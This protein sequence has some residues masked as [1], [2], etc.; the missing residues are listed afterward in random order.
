MSLQ[1]RF[2]EVDDLLLGEIRL[3]FC[4][5]FHD[6]VQASDPFLH[7]DIS[8]LETVELVPVVRQD[9]ASLVLDDVVM[10]ILASLIQ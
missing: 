1:H 4:P 2:N 8:R 3:G 10:R 7:L 9:I 6:I 5:L